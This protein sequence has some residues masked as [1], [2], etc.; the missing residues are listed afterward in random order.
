MFAVD[1]QLEEYP[2]MQAW[3]RVKFWAELSRVSIFWMSQVSDARTPLQLYLLTQNST[4][5]VHIFIE[6]RVL[7][8][9]FILQLFRNQS[10]FIFEAIKLNSSH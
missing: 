5:L 10:L 9:I 2:S 4:S 8:W 6:K 1:F 7:K 3:K